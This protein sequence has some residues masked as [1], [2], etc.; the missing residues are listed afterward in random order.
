MAA[1]F[2]TE[3]YR[4]GAVSGSAGSYERGQEKEEGREAGCALSWYRGSLCVGTGIAPFSRMV[5]ALIPKMISTSD[6]NITACRRPSSLIEP[7][8]RPQPPA[9]P[10]TAPSR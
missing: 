4:L 6:S 10:L 3:D 8:F 2:F 7:V 9:A 1:S 5:Y